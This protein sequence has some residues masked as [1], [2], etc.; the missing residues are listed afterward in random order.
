MSVMVH[1]DEEGSWKSDSVEYQGEGWDI[2]DGFN[3]GE[4]KVQNCRC[5]II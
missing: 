4:G 2:K 3:K 5:G 1:I